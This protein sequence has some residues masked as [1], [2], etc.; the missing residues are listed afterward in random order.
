[1]TDSESIKQGT[2]LAIQLIRSLVESELSKDKKPK[3]K[4]KPKPGD[5]EEG[6]GDKDEGELK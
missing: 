2:E 3:P 6:G 1:V 5:G 4:P